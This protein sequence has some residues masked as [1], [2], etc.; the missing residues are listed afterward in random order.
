M[1][2][3]EK[4]AREADRFFRREMMESEDYLNVTT[5]IKTT[6]SLREKMKDCAKAKNFSSL[7]SISAPR[8][9]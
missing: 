2:Q 6:E 1:P 9:F 3:L 7:R 5:R 8:S 4:L